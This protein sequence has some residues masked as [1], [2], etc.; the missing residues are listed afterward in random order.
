[1]ST[2]T[3]READERVR[4]AVM[5]QLDWD[6]EVDASDVHADA[7][8]EATSKKAAFAR[9]TSAFGVIVITSPSVC[10]R[11][12]AA[13][14]GHCANAVP[15]GRSRVDALKRLENARTVKLIDA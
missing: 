5:R 13:T 7:Q 1:M 14:H 12:I 15:G 9:S 8:R 3:L 2:A 6:P 11:Q 10:E 4:D